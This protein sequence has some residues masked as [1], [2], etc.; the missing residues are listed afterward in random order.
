VSS[1]PRDRLLRE[2]E[3]DRRIVTAVSAHP[4]VTFA[5][6]APSCAAMGTTGSEASGT[7]GA[8]GTCGQSLELVQSRFVTDDVAA[9]AAFYASVVGTCVVTNEYY[10]EVPTPAQRVALSRMRFSDVAGRTCGPPDGVTLGAVI[11][12]FAAADLDA[13]HRRLD[14]R[15]VDW[16]M[17]PTLQ[18][19]GR[20]S[21]MLRDPEG[22]LISVFEK[23]ESDG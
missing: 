3:T 1:S 2:D 19:W 23:K 16:L 6:A 12:D 22:H 8:G 20:R 13:E 15:G 9:M 5:V 14:A 17:P 4:A 21:M 18:P 7:A 11:L 10:V